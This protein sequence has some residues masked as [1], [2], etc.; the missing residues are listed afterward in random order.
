MEH[1]SH[2]R[3]VLVFSS[4][5]DIKF[6]INYGLPRRVDSFSLHALSPASLQGSIA[7]CDLEQHFLP[8]LFLEQYFPST[9]F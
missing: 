1:C 2:E 6:K 7:V 8:T 5:T 9:L 4:Y 3:Q